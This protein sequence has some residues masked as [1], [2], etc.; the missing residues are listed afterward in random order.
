MGGALEKASNRRGWKKQWQVGAW[1][2]DHDCSLGSSVLIAAV[3]TNRRLK[4]LTKDKDIK[5]IVSVRS[6]LKVNLMK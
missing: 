4:L 2:Q 6:E 1:V 3:C 5:A